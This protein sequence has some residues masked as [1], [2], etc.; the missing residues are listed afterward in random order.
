MSAARDRRRLRATSDEAFVIDSP[1]LPEELE[2]LPS[3]PRA[4]R[5]P[6]AAAGCWRRTATG[7]TCSVRS[8]SRRG[9][10]LR[11]RRQRGGCAPSR[12][13]RSAS[14]APSTKSSTSIARPA[15]ARSAA[16]AAGAR[17]LEIGD[18][19]A[20]AAPGRR[21]TPPTAWRSGRAG[22]GCSSAATTFA[23]ELPRLV[24]RGSVARRRPRGVSGARSR[25]QDM[26]S[27]SLAAP[28]SARWRRR[29]TS[30]PW[31][32]APVHPSARGGVSSA[33]SSE[34]PS[35]YL[36][37][38][39]ERGDA[40]PCSPRRRPLDRPSATCHE[41]NVA[42]LARRL[43]GL[44][45]GRLERV[46]QLRPPPER[47]SP[48]AARAAVDSPLADRWRSGRRPG[49]ARPRRSAA[50]RSCRPCGR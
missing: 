42:R 44:S 43:R 19:R 49:S 11:A 40:G 45:A 5:L 34:E 31:R 13:R 27:P 1:V 9:A 30:S 26:A 15:A 23:V 16:G 4:G 18:A 46:A 22:R 2:L 37:A 28:A 7:T 12:A 35:P 39:R 6:A 14:C 20:R 50:R 21:A 29:S 41:Q 36:L 33:R 48:R 24:A 25:C 38:L 17:A 47:A 3:A 32:T 10:R 8:L